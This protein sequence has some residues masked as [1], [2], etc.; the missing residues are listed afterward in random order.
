MKKISQVS[1]LSSLLFSVVST[2]LFAS[3]SLSEVTPYPQFCMQAAQ[4]ESLFSSFKRSPL[5]TGILEHISF[6][7]GQQSLEIALL[8]HPQWAT[9]LDLFRKNDLLGN[10][11][12][13]LYGQYGYF[14]PTTL[15]YI[16]V[17]S[18]LDQQMGSLN[19]KKI[20]E[21]GGGYGGQCLILSLLYDF[22]SYTIIDLPGPLALTKKYLELH[23]VKN[24]SYINALETIPLIK[25]D[26]IIS[27][28][29]LTECDRPVQDMYF[30]KIV[31]KASHGYLTCNYIPV[32]PG[33]SLYTREEL[34]NMVHAL[35]STS[36]ISEEIPNTHPN[37]YLLTW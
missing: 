13:F 31:S 8:A 5:Y 29:A 20:V 6:E 26:L 14:S 24:V 34:Y 32:E 16:K 19:R 12:V 17:A 28:Y 2:A 9:K 35:H 30:Q 22:S 15:R 27:N 4:N 1:L 23:G 11:L 18:D 25:S 3:T 37:N 33:I 7:T 21:I 10:P 36:R